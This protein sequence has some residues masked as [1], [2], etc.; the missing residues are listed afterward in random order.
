GF[1][2][3]KRSGSKRP[4]VVIF[5]T[6]YDEYAVKAFETNAVDYLLKPFTR[7][8]FEAALRKVKEQIHKKSIPDSAEQAFAVLRQLQNE[9]KY[10]QRIAVKSDHEIS[11]LRCEQIDWIESE[12]NYVLVHSGKH[13]HMIRES[14]NSMEQS[15]NPAHFL[16]IHRGTLVN[17][18]RIREM[19]GSSL[20]LEDGSSLSV[21][22]RMKPKVLHFFMKKQI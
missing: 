22:R 5:V 7:K 8:R 9:N 1:A 12:D 16:R 4:P 21:S 20:I 15:L 18:D 2:L 17:V 14:M 3:L 13:T 10:I 11:F 19:R 6:A